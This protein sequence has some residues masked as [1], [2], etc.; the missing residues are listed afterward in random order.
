MNGIITKGVNSMATISIQ[1]D[2]QSVNYETRFNLSVDASFSGVQGAIEN[3]EIKMFLPNYIEASLGSYGAP[4]RTVQEVEEQNGK[5]VVFG[6]G[7]VEDLGVAVRLDVNAGF[8]TST[9][10]NTVF[11]C[12]AELFINGVKTTTSVVNITLVAV[13]EYVISKEIILPSSAPSPGSEIYYRVTFENIGDLGVTVQNLRFECTGNDFIT[14]DGT[15]AVV[16][17]DK[18]SRFEDKS[19]DG[20]TG[21]ISNNLLTFDLASYKGQKYQFI[22]RANVSLEV[23]I[24]AELTTTVLYRINSVEMGSE[25]N[26]ITTAD[27]LYDPK[28]TLY[29]PDYT[30]PSEYICYRARVENAGNRIINLPEMQLLL[31][32]EMRCYRFTTGSFYIGAIKEN[33]SMQYTIEYETSNNTLGVL[34]PYNTDSNSTVNTDSF[35]GQGEYLVSLRWVFPSLGIGVRSRSNCTLYG[36]VEGDTPVPSEMSCR[37]DLDYQIDGADQNLLK[38][39]AT[40]VDDVCVLRPR[41]SSDIGGRNDIKPSDEIRYNLNIACIHSRLENPIVAVLIPKELTYIGGL[42]IR[43]ND[44]FGSISPPVP[45]A[46][47]VENFTG[48]NET[49][50]KFSFVGAYAYS[51]RQLAVINIAFDAAVKYDALGGI[52]AYGVLGCSDSVGVPASG[53][54]VHLDE[55]GIAPPSALGELCRSN[56]VSGTVI[57]FVSVSSNKLIMG[58][59]DEAY[60]E[61]PSVGRTYDG[62]KL[63]YKITVKNTG[64]AELISPEV[65]D[66]LPY[67]GD[68]GVILTG[69]VRRSEFAVYTISEVSA[70]LMPENSEVGIKIQYST[71][72]NPVRF[73]GNFNVIG[74]DNNWK[75]VPPDDITTLRAFRIKA[76]NVTLKP[77]RSLEI[78]VNAIVPIG[79]SE[80]SVAW[81]SFAANV[82]YKDEQGAVQQLL[83]VEPEKVGIKIEK[84]DEGTV[85]I[86]G[87]VFL[88]GDGDGLYEEGDANINDTGVALLDEELRVVDAV[89]TAPDADGNNG[90][91]LFSNIPSGKYYLRFFIDS[92]LYKFTTT[93][94]GITNGS[95]ADKRN[96]MTDLIDTDLNGS[97]T[98]IAAGLVNRDFISIKDVIKINKSARSV[99]RDVVKNQM[100]LVMKQEELSGLM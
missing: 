1:S 86:G 39:K 77:S 12:E 81:N 56:T 34:G 8:A 11:A 63:R 73:G 90:R 23:N 22:Y 98:D 46:E 4:I 75:N 42:D 49:L 41:L 88:D 13:A 74:V 69:S 92:R 29:G 64:N 97:I 21:V 78:D 51:F 18:S 87:V 62:G 91:F 33:I 35:L 44:I 40:I 76:E 68:T 32:E 9:L 25:Q 37:L 89:F 28:L 100:L 84:P 31:P 17:Y 45:P 7:A 71:S 79:V 36:I 65:V 5:T 16:G 6:L 85:R 53:Y 30:L 66:I 14:L 50:I 2:M 72:V 38:L 96:G 99:V 3:A 15:Y 61:E 58:A 55:Y 48:D 43:F 57:F 47:V 60:M 52:M 10:N 93:R 27:A 20:V 70:K 83:A 95:R 19:R 82:A 94:L 24:G 26:V 80:D 59:L 54:D 67:V